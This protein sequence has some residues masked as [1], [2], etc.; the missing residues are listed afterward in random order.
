MRILSLCALLIAL[1]FTACKKSESDD[2]LRNGASKEVNF[3]NKLNQPVH[4]RVYRDLDDYKRS[5]NPVLSTM[6]E[7]NERYL[8][9][10]PEEVDKYYFVDWY[11][12]NYVYGNWGYRKFAGA[13]PGGTPN[14]LSYEFLLPVTG[15]V[16]NIFYMTSASLNGGYGRNIALLGNNTESVWKSID[17]VDGGYLYKSKKNNVDGYKLYHEI[18][19]RKDMSCTYSYKLSD[20]SLRKLN[21]RYELVKSNTPMQRFKI[22]SEEGEHKSW[23]VLNTRTP[24]TYYNW[25][26]RDT[27]MMANNDGWV[28]FAR[29]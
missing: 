9:Q 15:I 21:T 24:L 5:V 17:I 16:N 14:Y 29:Q 7:P 19:L 12:E 13:F 11:S 28:V 1:S 3:N 4:I 22:Y 27:M 8:W 18:V 26:G 10:V 2:V 6:I 23:E 25:V 20:G